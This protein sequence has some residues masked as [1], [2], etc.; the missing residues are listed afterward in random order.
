[1]KKLTEAGYNERLFNG[2]LRGILHS[3][4]YHWLY[5]TIE[6]IGCDSNTVIELG[7]FDGKAI[8]YLP[9]SPSKYLGL[10]ANWE[11]GLDLARDKWRGHDRYRFQLCNKPEDIDLNGEKFDIAICMETLEH[12][13]T[14]LVAGYIEEL[15]KATKDYLFVSLPNEIGVVFF[16]KHLVKLLYGDREKYTLF[17]FLNQVI[18]RT[19]KVKRDNHKGFNYYHMIDQLEESFDIVDVSGFP[20]SRLPSYLNFGVGIVAK[21]KAG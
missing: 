16:F 13:P 6:S 14:G 4:R 19:H 3:A 18:G 15:S 9:K 8:D 20:L 2:G 10:D 17:E 5:S 1:M 7:C 21:R 11:G 12:I